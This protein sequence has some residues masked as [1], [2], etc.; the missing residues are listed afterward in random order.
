MIRT[1]S[2]CVV[3]A[4]LS[5]SGCTQFQVT[6]S[7]ML[8][9]DA[10]RTVSVENITSAEAT[11]DALKAIEEAKQSGLDFYS[12]LHIKEAERYLGKAQSLSR[13]HA[14]KRSEAASATSALMAIKVLEEAEANKSRLLTTLPE[15]F[16]QKHALDELG[17]DTTVD[18]SYKAM[19]RK[20]NSMIRYFEK[21]RMDKVAFLEAE[22]LGE[23]KAYESTATKAALLAPSK[24]MLLKAKELGALQYADKTYRHAVAEYRKTEKFIDEHVEDRASSEAKAKSTFNHAAQA[25]Y[26][27]LEARKIL[28]AN[29]NSAEQYVLSIQAYLNQ[30][31]QNAGVDALV[32]YSFKQQSELL[33]GA[34]HEKNSLIEAR[35]MAGPDSEACKAHSKEKAV[36]QEVET[37]DEHSNEIVEEAEIVDTPSSSKEPV[38]TEQVSAELNEEVAADLN[39]EEKIETT[40][41]EVASTNTDPAKAEPSSDVIDEMPMATKVIN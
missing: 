24:K 40:T 5:L 22:V 28:K 11:Y 26:V 30:I 7:R 37:V 4:S 21:G 8:Q 41:E 39:E 34:M 15:I 9:A 31:N 10:Y 20:M 35:A 3:A 17:A 27:T 2:I 29:T 13:M 12:P 14:S 1:I 18:S 32:S 19:I 6:N 33:M 23:L 25:F 36:M 16:K 38:I